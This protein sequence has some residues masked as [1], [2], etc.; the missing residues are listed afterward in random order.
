MSELCNKILFVCFCVF[1]CIPLLVLFVFS[2]FLY[3]LVELTGALMRGMMK[4]KRRA[5]AN[6]KNLANSLRNTWLDE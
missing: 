2:F 6:I 4:S 1:A 5:K 3:L